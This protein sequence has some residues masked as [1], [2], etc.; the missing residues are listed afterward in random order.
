MTATSRD[1]LEQT[2]EDL[3][4][5]AERLLDRPYEKGWF[6]A[7][8][9]GWKG[10]CELVERIETVTVVLEA[11]GYQPSDLRSSVSEDEIMVEAPDFS[12]RRAL[13]C[14]VDPESIQTEYRNGVLSIQIAKR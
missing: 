5:R 7:A 2:L 9:E 8:Q 10:R 4:K 12:V 6:S 11:P 1:S 3:V 13:P 14:R